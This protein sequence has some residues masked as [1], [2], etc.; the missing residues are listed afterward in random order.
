MRRLEAEN[1]Q[2]RAQLERQLAIYRE[3]AWELVALR[4]AMQ[5]IHEAMLHAKEAIEQ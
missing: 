2:L 3:Q 1:E 4:A 5:Q